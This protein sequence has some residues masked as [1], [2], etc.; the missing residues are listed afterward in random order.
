MI[1]GYVYIM[2]NKNRTTFYIGVTS[3]LMKRVLQHKLGLGSVFTT[4][5]KLKYLVYQEMIPGIKY[6]I[7]RE[8]QLKRWHREWKINL[9]KSINPTMVDLAGDWFDDDDLRC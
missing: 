6:A 4:K 2:S 7:K 1:I 8:K 9:I 3:N 5:Y